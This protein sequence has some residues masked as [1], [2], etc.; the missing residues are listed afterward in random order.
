MKPPSTDDIDSGANVGPLNEISLAVRTG[1]LVRLLKG[2]GLNRSTVD[3]LMRPE[4]LVKLKA[5]L[6]HHLLPENKPADGPDHGR[7][8]WR[9]TEDDPVVTES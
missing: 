9:E 2:Q 4:N 1:G 3:E 8:A 6:T 7:D 5:I